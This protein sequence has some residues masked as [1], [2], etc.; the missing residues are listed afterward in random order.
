VSS[1][2]LL[3]T[4]D[5][6]RALPPAA[7][8][9]AVEDAFRRLARGSV[10]APAILGLHAAEG[11]FH[12]KAGLLE[13]DR[14]YFAAKV[15]ANFPGNGPRNGLPTIQGVVYLCDAATGEPLAVMDSMSIT[16]LRT[17]AASAV[18]AK[19]L[20]LPECDT[21]LVCGCG[22]QAMAHVHALSSVR[23]PKRW[24]MFDQDRAKAVALARAIAAEGGIE[25]AAA[26]DLAEAAGRSRIIVTCTSARR[27]LIA[28]DMVRPG[29]FIA[30]VGADSED[31]QE[32]DPRL[33]AAAKVVTD[34]TAQ[35]A[36]IGDLHHAIVA[37]LMTTENVHAELGEVV[38]GLKPGRTRA[39][40]ICV[41]DS[42]GTGLQDVAAAIAA[43]RGAAG[44]SRQSAFDLA[45]RTA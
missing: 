22:R 15:N 41:F 2:L 18:A 23:R 42:T 38:A 39:D 5:V 35:A 34:L 21:A 4:A 33:L 12:V 6:G 10:P 25:A 14:P 37:G 3:S 31:K 45:G 27:Y 44:L 7:C 28:R 40:E 32:I 11:S 19:H 26:D 16:A 8:I 24:V 29:T 9:E 1:I 20:A 43:Y 13:A 30:A 36:A 17:A